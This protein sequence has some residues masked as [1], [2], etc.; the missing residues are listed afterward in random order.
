VIISPLDQV[1][2]NDLF[3]HNSPHALLIL[4]AL[5]FRLQNRGYVKPDQPRECA[6]IAEHFSPSGPAGPIAVVSAGH[7]GVNVEI[8]RKLE[9]GMWLRVLEKVFLKRSSVIY[10]VVGKADH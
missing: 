7:Q 1:Q 4:K 9:I 8:F 3:C 6:G 5:R 10:G 2:R